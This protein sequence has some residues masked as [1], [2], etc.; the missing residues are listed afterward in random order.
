MRQ[1][2]ILSILLVCANM[3]FGQNGN[4]VSKNTI[5]IIKS[6][7]WA[8]I[9]SND[10]I[11]SEYKFANNLNYSEIIYQSNSYYV[12]GFLITPKAKGHYPVIIFN[13]GGNRE[14]NKLT[15][16]TLFVSI[17]TLEHRI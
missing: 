10:S 1:I 13:R 3:S 17:N 9:S 11:K 6:E 2:I 12:E 5:D 14:F 16:K 7:L 8:F 4:I 15:L